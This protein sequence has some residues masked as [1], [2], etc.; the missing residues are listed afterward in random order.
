MKTKPRKFIKKPTEEYEIKFWKDW[1]EADPVKRLELVKK[2]PLFGMCLKMKDEKFWRGSFSS[3]ING[4][5]E[6]LESAVLTKVRLE[7][8]KRSGKR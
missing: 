6:D 2:L 1:L 7:K 5:F 8:T 4:Y 3:L